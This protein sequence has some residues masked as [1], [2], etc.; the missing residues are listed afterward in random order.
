M[1]Y[2]PKCLSEYVEGTNVC[3]DCR[4]PL[5][6]GSPPSSVAS[7]AE[8]ELPLDAK[9]VRIRTFSGPT[10]LL[11][12]DVARNILQAQGI[13][14]LVPGATSAELLPILDVPLL[15]PAEEAERA[16]EILRA[17]LDSSG[18]LPGE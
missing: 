16:V 5:Q 9:L 6:R 4:V 3:E 7:A 1:P 14:S 18:A 15:V 12:A 8:L 2:C 17:Y 13:P 10:A 11:D